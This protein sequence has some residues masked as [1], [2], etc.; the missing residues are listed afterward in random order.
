M[1]NKRFIQTMKEE[2]LYI[3]NGRTKKNWEGEYMYIGAR[4]STVIDYVFVNEHIQ[5]R[6]RE[7]IV[8]ERVDSDHMPICLE[9]EAEERR[10]QSRHSNEET[11]KRKIKQICVGMKY[12]EHYTERRPKNLDG[13]KPREIKQQKKYGKD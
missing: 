12:L 4:G 5:D 11:N 8:E 7:F 6:I 13:K 10:G 1:E 9:I 3:T 2:G